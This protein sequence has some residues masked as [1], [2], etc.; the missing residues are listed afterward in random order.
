MAG[1]Q[2]KDPCGNLNKSQGIVASLETSRIPLTI[3]GDDAKST[4]VG[5]EKAVLSDGA[6]D[7]PGRAQSASTSPTTTNTKGHDEDV[8]NEDDDPYQPLFEYIQVLEEDATLIEFN[9]TKVRIMQPS[10]GKTAPVLKV[11][12]SEPFWLAPVSNAIRKAFLQWR[13]EPMSYV[14]EAA[15]V[16]CDK[17]NGMIRDG[18]LPP[19]H[20]QCSGADSTWTT[21]ACAIC[22]MQTPCSSLKMTEDYGYRV[23]RQCIRIH[24]L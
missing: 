6:V 10:F 17:V 7:G 9:M 3:A 8:D 12:S 21:H 1:D 23:C 14:V 20:C 13:P 16:A 5:K 18:E 2:T 15:A 11:N 19:V 22:N 24:S 4:E